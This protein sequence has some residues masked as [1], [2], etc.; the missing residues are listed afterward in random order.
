[1]NDIASLIIGQL[2]YLNPGPR[3]KLIRKW[4]KALNLIEHEVFEDCED[5]RTYLRWLR[6]EVFKDEEKE[7]VQ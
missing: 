6:D 7:E 4:V 3:S 2:C 1:M 5:G